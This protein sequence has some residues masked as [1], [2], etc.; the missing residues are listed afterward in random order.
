MK[1]K[2]YDLPKYYDIAFSWDNSKE[3]NL[4]QMIFEKYV[5]YEAKNILE[6]ASGSGRFLMTFPKYEYHITGYD[7]NRRMVAYA[8]KRISDAG[9]QD[10]AKVIS[11]DMK[12]IKFKEKFDAAFNSINSIGYLLSDNEIISHFRNTGE[13]IKK[14]GIYIIHLACAA[15]KFEIY[16]TEN[17]GWVLEK[18]GIRVKTIWDIEK[19]DKQKKISYQVCKM[20]I[21]E[22]SKT[23][24]MEDHHKLRLWFFEDLKNL[25]RESGKFRLKAIYNEKDIQIPLDTHISGELGNLYYVL[26]VVE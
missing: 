17:E 11:G 3:I 22:N 2:L 13:S 16:E 25:I 18:D 20:T 24:V 19:E 5:P 10:F 6:P 21:T 9:F 14:G 12:S 4:F 1:K 15:D 8:R 23:F 7:N 26:K